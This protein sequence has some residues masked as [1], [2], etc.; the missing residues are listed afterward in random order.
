[1]P[2]PKVAPLL[3]QSFHSTREIWNVYFP[4]AVNTNKSEE[5]LIILMLQKWT[6]WWDE[7]PPGL[8]MGLGMVEEYCHL[9][10]WSY[11]VHVQGKT[12]QSSRQQAAP[13]DVSEPSGEKKNWKC[14]FCSIVNSTC[15]LVLTGLVSHLLCPRH[16]PNKGARKTL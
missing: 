2:K 13:S 15:T 9:L 16:C 5:K 8:G 10:A 3:K 14:L 11:N 4:S 6:L 1:M 7:A 12:V